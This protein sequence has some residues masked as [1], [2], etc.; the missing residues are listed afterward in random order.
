MGLNTASWFSNQSTNSITVLSGLSSSWVPACL[1][2]FPRSQLFSPLLPAQVSVSPQ[3]EITCCF[4]P[5]INNVFNSAG[6]SCRSLSLRSPQAKSWE[7]RERNEV[8]MGRWFE[9][10]K[11]KCISTIKGEVKKTKK[12]CSQCQRNSLTSLYKKHNKKAWG[13]TPLRYQR[14]THRCL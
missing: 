5:G 8:K 4:V 1:C 2:P 3:A 9:E 14:N 11:E 7:H 12:V 10:R 13:V 6:L